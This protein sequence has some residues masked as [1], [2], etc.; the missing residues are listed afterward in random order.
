[1]DVQ[2]LTST[3]YQ[4]QTKVANIKPFELFKDAK[5]SGVFLDR[6]DYKD[7]LLFALEC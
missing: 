6:Y 1:M 3:A 5:L 4:S 7:R 2:C